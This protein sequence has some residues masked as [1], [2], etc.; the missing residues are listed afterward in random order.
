MPLQITFNGFPLFSFGNQS[1]VILSESIIFTSDPK[2]NPVGLSNRCS[3]YVAAG[4]RLYIGSNSGF[5]GVS[6]FC[7]KDI[8]IGNNV[9]F[10]GNCWIWDTDFHPLNF[11]HRSSHDTSK[12]KSKN[13]YIGNDVLIGANSM[14]LKGV[15]IGDRSIIGAG[16]VVTKDVPS[17]EIWAGNPAHFIRNIKAANDIIDYEE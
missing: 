6:I 17:D 4:A 7:S 15:R 2:V 13:V 14:I 1:S 8:Y 10:G 12:I 3:I 16:S 11:K 9:N 5:S